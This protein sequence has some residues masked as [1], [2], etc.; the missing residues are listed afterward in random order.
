MK[1]K[2]IVPLIALSMTITGSSVLGS[3]DVYAYS[4]SS[5]TSQEISL[6]SAQPIYASKVKKCADTALKSSQNL[7]KSYI[8]ILI[9]AFSKLIK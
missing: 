9:E 8:G 5:L 1:N 7:Y 6:Y 4:A 2:I 3:V